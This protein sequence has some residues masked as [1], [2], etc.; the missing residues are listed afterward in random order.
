MMQKFLIGSAYS[1]ITIGIF[2]VLWSFRRSNRRNSKRKLIR[3][4][5]VGVIIALFG[6]LILIFFQYATQP[7]PE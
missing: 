4:G 5:G 3:V 1:L 6:G 2:F 7:V